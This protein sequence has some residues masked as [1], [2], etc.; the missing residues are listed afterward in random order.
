MSWDEECKAEDFD[1]RP[2]NL[3][4]TPLTGDSVR[5]EW[6][7]K[8]PT[9]DTYN[10]YYPHENGYDVNVGSVVGEVE[11]L[12]Y[13]VEAKFNVSQATEFSAWKITYMDRWGNYQSVQ[14]GPFT[15]GGNA[16]VPSNLLVTPNMDGTYTITWKTQ[17][18]PNHYYFYIRRSDYDWMAN[19]TLTEASYKTEVLATGYEYYVT[20]DSRDAEDNS[21]GYAWTTFSTSTVS[22]KDI[23]LN[24]YIP[25]NAG[26]SST[27][28]YALL[29]NYPGFAKQV[30]PLTLDSNRWYSTTISVTKEKINVSLIN[31]LTEEKATEEIAYKSEIN[32][33]AIL[34]A[35]KNQAGKLFLS[36][37]DPDYNGSD[38]CPY[39][40][41]AEAKNGQLILAWEAAQDAPST[42]P[43]S[44]PPPSRPSTT[45]ACWS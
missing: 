24:V 40:L 35:N 20:I 36:D 3:K 30:A 37:I 33:D 42:S 39:N 41:Q 12:H 10:V 38:L 23:K 26:L 7:V 22:P 13:V 27:E 14:G 11:K 44:T 25:Q 34:I 9:N 8:N 16:Y 18:A 6:D 4:V 1:Y 17:S 43:A 21:L 19:S 5:F 28:G 2:Y 15:V 31:A 29:W 32:S 45:R